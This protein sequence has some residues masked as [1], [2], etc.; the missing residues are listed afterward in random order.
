M[1]GQSPLV[2][3]RCSNAAQDIMMF[4]SPDQTLADRA[5]TRSKV[6]P[7][8]K[9][10]LFSNRAEPASSRAAT[11]QSSQAYRGISVASRAPARPAGVPVRLA[12]AQDSLPLQSRT[13]RVCGCSNTLFVCRT[14]AVG[15]EVGG[16]SSNHGSSR[17]YSTTFPGVG[18][19][20]LGRSGCR[21]DS[22]CPPRKHATVHHAR[23]LS[24]RHSHLVT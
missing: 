19:L 12:G 22:C 7:T 17:H 20:S 11:G 21:R 14:R 15:V 18:L 13:G 3:Q 10:N 23:G 16:S 2:F 24:R 9:E 4:G 6:H 8:G 1:A 5:Q